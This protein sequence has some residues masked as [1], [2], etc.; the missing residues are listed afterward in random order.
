MALGPTQPLIQ[1]VLRTLSPGLKRQGHEANHSLQFNA[2]V[3]NNGAI[4]PLPH[5]S[6]LCGA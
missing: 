6:S 5:M 4:P 1:E 3:K 2:E